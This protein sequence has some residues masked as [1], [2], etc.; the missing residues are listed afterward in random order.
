MNVEAILSTRCMK[1]KVKDLLIAFFV[2][3]HILQVIKH[4]LLKIQPLRL[5]LKWVQLFGSLA[6]YVII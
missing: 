2:F 5:K 1:I 3:L 4:S 6:G